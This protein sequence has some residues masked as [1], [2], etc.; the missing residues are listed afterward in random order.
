MQLW[1][2]N[3]PCS[4]YFPIDC[5][6]PSTNLPFTTVFPEHIGTWMSLPCLRK[7]QH[8]VLLSFLFL[9]GRA[10]AILGGLPADKMRSCAKPTSQ[11]WT[12]SWC[13]ITLMHNYMSFIAK[14]MRANKYKHSML[15]YLYIELEYFTDWRET[16][17]GW[18]PF[19]TVTLCHPMSKCRYGQN[20]LHVFI[21]RILWGVCNLP[22]RMLDAPWGKINLLA[23]CCHVYPFGSSNLHEHRACHGGTMSGRDC[24]APESLG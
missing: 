20:S 7:H 3:V 4:I 23:F 17:F 16:S 22:S 5:Q 18:F 1:L 13:Q 19:V 2:G 24:I 12:I 14:N 8:L 21:V 9:L 6:K 11:G 15:Y 10:I